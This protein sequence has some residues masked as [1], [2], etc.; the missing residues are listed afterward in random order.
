LD[1][2]GHALAKDF[3]ELLDKHDLRKKIITYVKN[4]RFNLN[5]MTVALKYVLSCDI[6]N[7]AKNF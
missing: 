1:T 5:I 7:L 3:F 2:I 6:L 4:E